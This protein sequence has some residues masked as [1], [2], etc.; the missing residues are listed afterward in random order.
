MTDQHM[1]HAT[2]SQSFLDQKDKHIQNHFYLH[3]DRPL[4][5]I[6]LAQQF[7]HRN[8]MNHTPVHS[9]IYLLENKKFEQSNMYYKKLI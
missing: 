8:T 9:I 5:Q 4:Y 1:K 7:V 6:F 2:H 3:T